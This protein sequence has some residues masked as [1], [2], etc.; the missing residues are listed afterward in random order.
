MKEKAEKMDEIIQKYTEEA[1]KSGSELFYDFFVNPDVSMELMIGPLEVS[2]GLT[3]HLAEK[4]AERNGIKLTR[5]DFARGKWSEPPDHRT[6]FSVTVP[7][8]ETEFENTV[9]KL[10]EA[11]KELKE[12]TNRIIENL[13]Y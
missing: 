7:D 13:G 8:D 12:A 3:Y 2:A 9:E 6:V 5:Y 1:K 4:I 10:C 11:S